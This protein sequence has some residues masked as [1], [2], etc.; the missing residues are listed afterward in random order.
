MREKLASQRKAESGSQVIQTRSK[1]NSLELSI[2][3]AIDGHNSALSVNSKLRAAIDE[4][5]INK[6]NLKQQ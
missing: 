5:R 6:N 3:D 4:R 1:I 2:Q